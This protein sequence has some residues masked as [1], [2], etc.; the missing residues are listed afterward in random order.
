MDLRKKSTY[1]LWQKWAAVT[2]ALLRRVASVYE[3]RGTKKE[4][5]AEKVGTLLERISLFIDPLKHAQELAELGYDVRGSF[6]KLYLL[7]LNSLKGIFASFNG[8][9]PA[10]SE[11]MQRLLESPCFGDCNGREASDIF[12]GPHRSE[13]EGLG[14][15]DGSEYGTL[16]WMLAKLLEE[17]EVGGQAYFQ[18]G[19]EKKDEGDGEDE[20]DP[21][22]L[23]RHDIKRPPKKITATGVQ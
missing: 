18:R 16:P 12:K 20:S 10:L 6:N 21:P 11:D 5:N 19:L 23:A 4:R 17:A 9:S 14:S 3:K 2:Q 7:S 1:E 15:G 8:L 13:C 22:A